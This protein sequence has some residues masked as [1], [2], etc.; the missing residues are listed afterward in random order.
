MPLLPPVTRTTFSWSRGPRLGR[1]RRIEVELDLRAHGIVAEK[2]PDAGAD[3]LAD[4]V[5]DAVLLQARDRPFRSLA[6]NAM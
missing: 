6:L 5:L 4:N 1:L 3:L 2:L